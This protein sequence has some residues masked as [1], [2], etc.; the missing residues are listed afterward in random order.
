ARLHAAAEQW[1]ALRPGLPDRVQGLVWQGRIYGY[2]RDHDKS[3][4]KYREALALDP[5]HF[6][7]RYHLAIALVQ[8]APDEC[9]R[10]FDILIHQ[11]PGNRFIR[12]L[13]ATTRRR[14]GQF[15]GARQVLDTML[16]ADPNDFAALIELAQLNMDEGKPAAAEPLLERALRLG[17]NVPEANLAMSRC[18]QLAGRPDRAEHYR[19]RF[20]ETDAE[21]RRPRGQTPLPQP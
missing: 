17:P 19:K 14:F 21:R 10:H 20:E 12:F 18:Q 2:A 6:E 1:L 4:A 5:N 3:L 11:K 8:S 13:V 16:A 7:A 15:A 9:L